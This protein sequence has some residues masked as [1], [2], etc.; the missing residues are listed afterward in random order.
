MTE[1][2]A[3]AVNKR[4]TDKRERIAKSQRAARK[5]R[6]SIQN[7]GARNVK[8]QRALNAALSWQKET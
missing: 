8:L 3:S 7:A 5:V 6:E 4:E 2:Q 1:R